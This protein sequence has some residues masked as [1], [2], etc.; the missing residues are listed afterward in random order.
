[1]EEKKTNKWLIPV[2]IGCV[3]LLCLCV[4]IPAI[5]YFTLGNTFTDQIPFDIDGFT[6]LGVPEQ[7]GPTVDIPPVNTDST[8]PEIDVEPPSNVGPDVPTGPTGKEMT[9]G[10]YVTDTE[11]FDDFS[12]DA[13]EWPI[14]DDGITILKYENQGYSFEITQPDYVDWAYVPTPFFPSKIQFDIEGTST[15]EDGTFGV[16]CNYQDEDNYDYAEFSLHYLDVV[17]G[18]TR[19]GEYSYLTEQ[20]PDGEYYLELSNMY[21]YSTPNTIKMDCTPTLLTLWV[22]G[23]LE[24]E[25]PIASPLPDLGDMALFIYTYEDAAN[26][27]KVI[28]DN[29]LVEE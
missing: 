28:F 19:D 18:M 29:V 7:D 2:G 4:V 26:G 20:N 9:G 6:D 17:F 22:N 3:V 15:Y 11:L 21:S 14:Y 12:S 24:F 10:Q 27:Y 16:F 8:D 1:M 23:Q 13:L 5:L 25:I